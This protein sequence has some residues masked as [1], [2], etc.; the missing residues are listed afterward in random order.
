MALLTKVQTEPLLEL[1][2]GASYQLG[3]LPSAGD[4][5][6]TGRQVFVLSNSGKPVYCRYGNENAMSTLFGVM[7]VFRGLYMAES[8]LVNA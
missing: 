2:R 6:A 5:P 8:Y 1:A 4:S 7:Q 3:T